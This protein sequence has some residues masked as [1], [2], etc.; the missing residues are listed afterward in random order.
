MALYLYF[1]P[2]QKLK[3]PQFKRETLRI[4]RKKI[5]KRKLVICLEMAT[6]SN[7]HFI[8]THIRNSFIT[9]DDTGEL[10]I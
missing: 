2:L 1:Q 4:T 5:E 6:Y 8:L 10:I 3:G 9:T 7:P